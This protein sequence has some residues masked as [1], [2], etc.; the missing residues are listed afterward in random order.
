MTASIN[1]NTVPAWQRDQVYYAGDLVTIG[2]VTCEANWWTEGADP[3]LNNGVLG[4]GKSGTIVSSGTNSVGGGSGGTA[5]NIPDSFAV[6]S[7]M[8]RS[9]TLTWSAAVVSG[10]G[11]HLLRQ[12]Q[13]RHTDRVNSTAHRSATRNG[14]ER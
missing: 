5:P 6:T 10:G 12:L 4:T 9:V 1:S 14:I 3:A 8:S 13:K 7:I 2:S 11:G